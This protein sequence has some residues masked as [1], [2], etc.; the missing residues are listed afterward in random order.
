MKRK[1]LNIILSFFMVMLCCT[2]IAR[3]AASLT[4]AKVKTEGLNRGSLVE[5]FDG[6]GSI[7]AKDKIYQSLPEIGRAHV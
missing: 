1:I 5:E 4:V 2:L 3:G 7:K 6:E